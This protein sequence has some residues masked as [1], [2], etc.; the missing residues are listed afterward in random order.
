LSIVRRTA[1]LPGVI[2]GTP[3]TAWRYCTIVAVVKGPST[4]PLPSPRSAAL[5]QVDDSV[6]YKLS[7]R[8]QTKPPRGVLGN[9]HG[10][11][12]AERRSIFQIRAAQDS[13]QETIVA[14]AGCPAFTS[15]AGCAIQ[16]LGRGRIHAETVRYF[17]KRAS[18]RRGKQCY[19]QVS[20]N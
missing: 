8:I 2:T 4:G 12:P 3:F 7:V 16:A 17:A 15:H 20:G 6:E 14:D 19:A 18:I 1:P 9:G 11:L 10:L 5:T 13:G